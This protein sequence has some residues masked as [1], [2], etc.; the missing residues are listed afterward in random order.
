MYSIWHHTLHFIQV[1]IWHHAHCASSALSPRHHF[2]FNL[3]FQ[4]KVYT[5]HSHLSH[6]LEVISTLTRLAVNRESGACIL[7]WFWKTFRLLRSSINQRT[8]LAFSII[9]SKLL[10][11]CI[12]SSLLIYPQGL[13]QELITSLQIPSMRNHGRHR[14]RG[15]GWMLKR[16]R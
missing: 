7:N 2:K 15:H 5:L 6:H 13:L 8:P 10:S 14:R 11:V 12:F 9:N 1:F 4:L 16:E 3:S